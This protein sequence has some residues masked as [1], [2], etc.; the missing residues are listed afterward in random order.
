[1][2]Y[3]DADGEDAAIEQPTIALFAE[4]GWETINCY[5]ESVGPSSLLRRDTTADVLLPFRLRS[6]LE[7]LNPAISPTALDLAIAELSNSLLV[8]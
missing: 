7:K 5:H 6:A 3:G 4:L 1:M 8:T 2:S